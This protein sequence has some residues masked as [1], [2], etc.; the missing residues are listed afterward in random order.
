MDRASNPTPNDQVLAREER[1]LVGET[2]LHA[3]QAVAVTG[4]RGQFVFQAVVV[5]RRTGARWANVFG[6]PKGRERVRSVPP[7]RLR[8]A[9]PARG[10]P[11]PE[12]LTLEL[13]PRLPGRG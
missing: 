11:R 6:G 5:N 1:V 8:P 7:D 9:S 3:G 13:G 4:L 2:V 12:Q 10:G